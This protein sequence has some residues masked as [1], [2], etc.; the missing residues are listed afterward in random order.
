M[1]GIRVGL[2]TRVLL[3][4]FE[5]DGCPSV[6]ILIFLDYFEFSRTNLDN[7]IKMLVSKDTSTM[8]C[9]IATVSTIWAQT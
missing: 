5:Q 6:S 1:Y 9:L 8:V 4:G 2:G 3:N 7:L